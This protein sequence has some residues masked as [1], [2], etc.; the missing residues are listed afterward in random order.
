MPR[1]Y[2]D[3]L[4]QYQGLHQLSTVGSW[5]LGMGFFIMAGM[6]ISSLKS[7]KK[8]PR[9]PWGS[10]ALEWQTTT[11]PP[12]ANF[13]KEPVVTRGPYDYHLATEQELSVD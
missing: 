2:Y 9:N 8:A 7:G 6:F 4:P 1:R 11:P 10:C 13:I 5:V 3:Y 12:V